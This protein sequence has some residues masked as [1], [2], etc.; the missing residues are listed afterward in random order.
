MAPPVAKLFMGRTVTEQAVSYVGTNQAIYLIDLRRTL[1]D[2]V[3]FDRNVVR[4]NFKKRIIPGR[5][6]AFAEGNVR[7]EFSPKTLFDTLHLAMRP[8]PG[9]GIEIN[10]GDDSA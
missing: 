7:L 3:Q 9:G 8:V 2:S 6:E 4:T 5:A 10:P 1:P